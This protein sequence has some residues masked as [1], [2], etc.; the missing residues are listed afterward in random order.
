MS[1]FASPATSRLRLKDS[2]WFRQTAYAIAAGFIIGLFLSAITIIIDLRAERQDL[3]SKILQVIDSVSE[4]AAQAV[5]NIDNQLA[6]TVVEGLY[7][8]QVIREVILIDDLGQ[9]LAKVSRPGGDDVQGRLANKLFEDELSLSVDIFAINSTTKIGRIDVEVDASLVASQFFKRSAL[10][11]IG[12][13]VRNILL[14]ICLL[15]LFFVTLTKPLTKLAHD[16]SEIDPENPD[17]RI[18]VSPSL[19][20]SELGD[21]TNVLNGLLSSLSRVQRSQV[22]TQSI[23]Q[24]HRDHLEELVEARTAELEQRNQELRREGEIRQETEERLRLSRQEALDASLAKSAFLANMS[25][26]LRSPLNAIIGFSQLMDNR[27]FGPMGDSHY[28]AYAKDILASGELLLSLVNDLLDLSKIEAGEYDLE[29][30]PV[31]LG[32][33]LGFCFNIVEPQ[34][35]DKR[36]TLLLQ[37]DDVGQ[38]VL[39]ADDRALKQITLN[40]L[41]NAVKFTPQG[42]KVV[43]SYGLNGEGAPFFTVSDTGIGMS[44][45]D[46]VNAFLPFRQSSDPRVTSQTGTGLG[47]TL[48]RELVELHGGKI[49]IDSTLGKGTEVTVNLPTERMV[50]S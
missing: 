2:L 22:E 27:T 9:P 42:G 32:Q 28:E 44:A 30:R 39:M 47:L 6:R 21:I 41:T 36:L 1:D 16:I 43:L 23:L 4:P 33:I 31:S 5:F 48:T 25:H 40:L 12:G 37:D 24:Q 20:K 35:R 34:A 13:L 18:S 17:R 50:R 3:N 26:E 46:R 45:D 14:S 8:Y 19:E 38:I 10:T 11:L 49:R 7:R 29:E 15:A